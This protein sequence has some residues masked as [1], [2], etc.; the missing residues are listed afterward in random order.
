MNVITMPI[1]Y[2]GRITIFLIHELG[3]IFIFFINGFSHIFT[4][5]FQTKKIIQQVYFIGVKSFFVIVLIGIFTGMVMALQGYYVL[6]KVGTEGLLG[7][8]VALALIRELGPV[9]GAIMIVGRAGSSMA[10]E[11]GIMR[12]TEQI[13]ALYTMD[14]NPVKYLFS[15]RIVAALISFPLLIALFDVVGI[16]GG[17]MVG[18]FLLGVDPG[19]FISKMITMVTIEDVRGGFY[20]AIIFG[21][22]VVT[23]CCYQG[24]FVH[25]R[26]EAF[27]AKG[28][29]FATTSAVVLSCVIILAVDYVITSF[30]L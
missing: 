29:S 24:Y 9:L 15:P 30:L 25:T 16:F 7:A 20:K 14:I 4:Y 3:S 19:A 2:L 26:R 11:I 21:A 17:Y 18:V 8:G 23:I 6:V 5:P 10:A 12:I 13:D 27:G 1:S 22:V 28:V